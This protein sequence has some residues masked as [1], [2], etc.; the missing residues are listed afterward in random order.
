MN[1]DLQLFDVIP[2]L[3]VLCRIASWTSAPSADAIASILWSGHWTAITTTTRSIIDRP[4][5]RILRRPSGLRAHRIASVCLSVCRHVGSRRAEALFDA[6]PARVP[7]VQEGVPH[8]GDDL[9]RRGRIQVRGRPP[10]TQVR[11]VE[12]GARP[13][14]VGRHGPG[15]GGGVLQEATLTAVHLQGTLMVLHLELAYGAMVEFLVIPSVRIHAC[16]RKGGRTWTH[17]STH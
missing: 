3:T 16:M 5:T 14:E 15:G 13:K 11:R 9:Q 12:E 17:R 4:S 2:P 1:Y 10:Q 7:P 8:D 6:R